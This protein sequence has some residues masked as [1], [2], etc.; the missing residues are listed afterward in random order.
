[1]HWE[2]AGKGESV[3][4]KRGTRRGERFVE[5]LHAKRVGAEIGAHKAE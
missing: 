3:S 5:I 1:M 4:E 2:I